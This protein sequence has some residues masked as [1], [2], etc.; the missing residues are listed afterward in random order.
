ME[1]VIHHY[2]DCRDL[3][4]GFT[5]VKCKDCGHGYLL[6]FTCKCRCFRMVIFDAFLASIPRLCR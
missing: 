4:N 6:A 1:Q 2:L 3:H 5:H